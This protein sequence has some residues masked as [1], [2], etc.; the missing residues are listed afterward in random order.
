M[1]WLVALVSVM[2]VLIVVGVGVVGVTILH[3]A[4]VG[5][6]A[7]TPADMVLNEPSGTRLVGVAGV[8][9]RLAV[10]L[11][12]GGADRVAIVDLRRGAIVSH[13]SLK[14]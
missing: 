10:A 8:G 9:D 4:G 7:G 13:I 12:G 11:T 14:P 2:G 1:R 5:A 3:R 6:G